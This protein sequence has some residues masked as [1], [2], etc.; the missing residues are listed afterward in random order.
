MVY[1]PSQTAPKRVIGALAA[2]LAVVAFVAVTH[3]QASGSKTASTPTSLAASTDL[4]WH[5]FDNQYPEFVSA[6]TTELGSVPWACT[7]KQYSLCGHCGS[8]QD[9]S[10]CWSKCAKSHAGELRQICGFGATTELAACDKSFCYST[11]PKY[12]CCA[13][14]GKCPG[15]GSAE[16]RQCFNRCN[17]CPR[18]ATATELSLWRSV[19]TYR[20]NEGVFGL[21]HGDGSMYCRDCTGFGFYGSCYKYGDAREQSIKTCAQRGYTESCDVGVAGAKCRPGEEKEKPN[22]GLCPEG[23]LNG[24][25]PRGK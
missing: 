20:Y 16:A 22:W 7:M 21:F 6:A 23:L 1:A 4:K 2:T 5:N 15:C 3:D 19:L 18:A 17:G 25:I 24:C 12:S 14:G 8:P 10:D 11:C 9:N 13:N